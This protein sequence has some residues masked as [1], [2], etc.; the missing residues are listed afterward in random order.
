VLFWRI[1][2]LLGGFWPS[3]ISCFLVVMLHALP[4]KWIHGIIIYSGVLSQPK[5]T[6]MIITQLEDHD[7]TCLISIFVAHKIIND[8]NED[9]HYTRSL[10]CAHCHNL[11][12]IWLKKIKNEKNVHKTIKTISNLSYIYIYV[13]KWNHKSMCSFVHAW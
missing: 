13:R 11:F 3:I 6:Y 1:L 5:L 9:L 12:D 8:V 2:A 10:L 4:P 7:Y